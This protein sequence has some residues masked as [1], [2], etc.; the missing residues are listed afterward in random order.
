MGQAAPSRLVA[1]KGSDAAAYLFWSRMPVLEQNDYKIVISDQRF[2]DP[3]VGD[4]FTLRI[5]E[6]KP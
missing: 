6:P 1:D 3:R 2:K 5:N 4:R